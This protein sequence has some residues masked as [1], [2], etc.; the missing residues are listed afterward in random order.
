MRQ[1][2]RIE[3]KLAKI[4]DKLDLHLERLSKAESSVEWLKGS[5]KI[6]ITVILAA[7][8]GAVGFILKLK[9]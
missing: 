9:F 2:D 4:D 5:V 3:D 8:T 6:T 1:M 7:L